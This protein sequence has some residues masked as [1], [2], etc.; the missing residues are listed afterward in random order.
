MKSSH[1]KYESRYEILSVKYERAMK[2]KMLLK[3]EKERLV[4]RSVDLKNSEK[5]LKE[6]I[7]KEFGDPEEEIRKRK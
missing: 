6:K 1:E 5:E 7:A 2:E 3:L 4:I